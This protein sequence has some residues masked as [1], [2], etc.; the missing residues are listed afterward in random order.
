M[1]DK[2]KKD[3]MDN[4][5]LR[6]PGCGKHC[7]YGKAGCKYGEKYF[8]K[9]NSA[10]AKAEKTDKSKWETLV[11]EGTWLYSLLSVSRSVR[12]ALVKD[13]VNEYTLVNALTNDEAAQLVQ[14][15]N[16]LE[17]AGTKSKKDV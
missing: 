13:K 11:T 6:C 9:L 15:L 16:K 4:K 14:I 10:P 1:K 3:N 12:K 5:S 7:P 8:A 2:N 17:K